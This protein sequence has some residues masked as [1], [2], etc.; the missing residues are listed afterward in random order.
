MDDFDF[1][2]NSYENDDEDQYEQDDE[3]P[4]ESYSMDDVPIAEKDSEKGYECIT[5]EQILRRQNEALEQV[6]SIFSD[7]SLSQARTLLQHFRWD[8]SELL[9][10]YSDNPEKL[11]AKVGL[12]TSTTSS[13]TTFSSS[14]S[15]STSSSTSSS[16]NITSQCLICYDDFEHSS[17]IPVPSCGHN[18]CQGCWEEYLRLEVDQKKKLVL[19]PGSTG[20]QK[21]CRVLDDCFVSSLLTQ[22][23]DKYLDS[24]RNSF[25][26][27][28]PQAAWCPKPGCQNAVI[29]TEVS[30][31]HN[32]GVRCLCG[33]RFCFRCLREDHRPATCE[34]LT[35]WLKKIRTGEAL[36]D[37]VISINCR[38]CPK[39]KAPVLK[40]G[41]CNHITCSVCMF[42]F[43]WQCLS[44]FGDG[45][46]G[47]LDGYQKHRCNSFKEDDHLLHE[48]KEELARFEWYFDRYNNHAKS[49][50]LEQ[51]QLKNKPITCSST[52]STKR[53]S[54]DSNHDQDEYSLI[55]STVSFYHDAVDQLLTNRVTLKNSY[56]YGYYRPLQAAHVNKL[57]FENLQ[58]DVERHTEKLSHLLTPSFSTIFRDQP[59]ILSHTKLA[60]RVRDALFDSTHW[61]P[62]SDPLK[63]DGADSSVRDPSNS[64]KKKSSELDEE[65]NN[66]SSQRKGKQPEDSPPEIPTRGL[67]RKNSKTKAPK[68]TPPPKP[69]RKKPAKTLHKENSDAE[70]QLAIL[71]SLRNC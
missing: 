21:C 63:A 11:S 8:V 31:E 4:E 27:D 43:C 36:N 59:N 12:C 44:K 57:I 32:E 25:V 60:A 56:V 24:L 39:C 1:Y 38:P 66:N 64:A 2:D 35:E 45:P 67:K 69:P 10:E 16:S 55:S 5:P 65:D 62:S 47:G 23:R 33:H 37:A 22:N 18:F 26:E 19:C 20:K 50:Q 61:S 9:A 54:K 46:L 49:L 58:I 68:K 28:N 48:K 34:M 41:G 52:S 70:L 30:Q 15:T 6:K 14:S 3:D 7:I 13:S 51:K 29:L 17:N 71:Q 40:D 42:H 53:T